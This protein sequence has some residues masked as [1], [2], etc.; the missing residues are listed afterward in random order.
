[1]GLRWEAAAELLLRKMGYRVL[2]AQH[3]AEQVKRDRKLQKLHKDTEHDYYLW[4]YVDYIVARGP[5][6]RLVDVKSKP[7]QLFKEGRKWVTF[8]NQSVSFTS[9]EMSAYPDARIP[10]HILLIRYRDNDDV[11]KLGPVQYCFAP[12]SD[13]YFTETWAGGF[14]PKT[15]RWK[16]LSSTE[17]YNLLRKTKAPDLAES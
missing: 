5:L 10:V 1:M 7:L 17:A 13:F 12:F 2:K 9:K 14:P 3:R 15:A 11:R 16:T 6:I 8:G 4:N